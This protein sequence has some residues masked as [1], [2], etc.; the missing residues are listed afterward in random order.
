MSETNDALWLAF[1]ALARAYPHDGG[2]RMTADLGRWLVEEHERH[3]VRT[4]PTLKM[5]SADRMPR[6]AYLA[7]KMIC[8]SRRT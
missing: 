4:P 2:V 7:V 8:R 1:E 5:V 3:Q 6:T